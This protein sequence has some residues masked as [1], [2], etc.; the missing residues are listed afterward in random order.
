[1]QLC[2]VLQQAL[3]PEAI[4]LRAEPGPVLTPLTQGNATPYLPPP[5]VV[6]PCSPQPDFLCPRS[7]TPPPH[8]PRT[9]P[10]PPPPKKK[11]P[12]PR[13]FLDPWQSDFVSKV[14]GLV[15]GKLLEGVADVRDESDREAGLRVVVEVK[16]G[17]RAEVRVCGACGVGGWG[18]RGGVGRG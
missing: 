18:G 5:P 10:A 2:S 4:A 11:L 14:A 16:K 15:D 12:N 17:F 9:Y 1:M 3:P 8:R 7:L 6:L 13:P